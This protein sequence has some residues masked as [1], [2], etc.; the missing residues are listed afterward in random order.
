MAVAL[1][2]STIVTDE[3]ARLEEVSVAMRSKIAILLTVMGLMLTVFA[4]AALV[5]TFFG[6]DGPDT[7][8]GTPQ[9]DLLR[10][11]GGNDTINGWSDHDTVFGGS[12]AGVVRAR[13]RGRHH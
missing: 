2:S 3:K 8:I 12:G 7:L 13:R 4:G 5:A 11:R 9:N 1:P 10:G 6:T